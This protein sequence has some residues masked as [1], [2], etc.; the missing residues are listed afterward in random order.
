MATKR[1]GPGG[2]RGKTEIRTCLKYYRRHPS[3]CRSRSGVKNQTNGEG[4]KTELQKFAACISA[5]VEV[6]PGETARLLCRPAVRSDRRRRPHQPQYGHPRLWPA[7]EITTRSRTGRT[8]PGTRAHSRKAQSPHSTSALRRGR[9][10]FAPAFS[11]MVGVDAD[12]LLAGRP[13]HPALVA[14]RQSLGGP[15]VRPP[16]SNPCDAEQRGSRG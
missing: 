13:H 11:R 4:G 9:A 15:P 10:V 7:G 16:R 8:P 14:P 12:E 1:R 5:H 6:A 3:M 2:Q